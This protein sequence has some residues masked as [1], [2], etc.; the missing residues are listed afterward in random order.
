MWHSHYYLRINFHQHFILIGHG[1][2]HHSC[3]CS[4]IVHVACLS[5][6]PLNP[7]LRYHD[8]W[9]LHL[10]HGYVCV[11]N[12]AYGH[13][14]MIVLQKHISMHLHKYSYGSCESV[15]HAPLSRPATLHVI[16]QL[17]TSGYFRSSHILPTPSDLYIQYYIY[18]TAQCKL[19]RCKCSICSNGRMKKHRQHK[20]QRVMPPCV[21]VD[22]LR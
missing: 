11:M 17:L 14:Y 21:Q 15:I 16:I 5:A 8:F 1:C 4:W 7:Q 22:Y 20:L 12:H 18:T 19:P 3:Q 9:I 10:Q 6:F 13:H 2:V